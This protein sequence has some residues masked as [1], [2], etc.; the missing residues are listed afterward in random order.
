MSALPKRARAVVR[1]LAI[2]LVLN[3]A[4]ALAKWIV[5]RAMGSLALTADALHSTLDAASN[6]VGIV[7][8]VIG[9]K[10]PDAGHPYGHRRFEAMTAVVIGVLIAAGLLAVLESVFQRE[11][12]AGATPS[13]VGV[14]VVVATFF[15]NLGVSRY[16]RRRAA[17][18]SSSVLAAD[19]GHTM[20][21]A[22]ASLV[23]LASLGGAAMGWRW[24]DL[25][26]AVVVCVFIAHTAFR[27]L[28][29]NVD[30]LADGVRLDAQE[31]ARLVNAVD[32]VTGAHRIRSRGSADHVQ[33]DLHV[34][35]DPAF[36][37][38]QAHDKTHQV[39]DVLTDAYPEV[40][41]VVVHTEPA[42]ADGRCADDAPTAPS[43]SDP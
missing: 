27:I 32:G 36:T 15:I 42:T 18:L 41:D 29:S 38:R 19:A 23:V 17:A 5:G 24:A 43:S 7:G 16:E 22:L 8:T 34:H 30:S 40:C 39:M 4:V 14:A 35:L 6:V 20:S 11:S 25:V 26:A 3:L 1:V 2:V 37:I 31:V 33:V 10:P 9:A 12:A 21:D 28:S 13:L